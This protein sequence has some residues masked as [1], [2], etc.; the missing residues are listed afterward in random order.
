MAMTRIVPQPERQPSPAWGINA[1]A[2]W[3]KQVSA[4][5]P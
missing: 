4:G 5:G 3:E 2:D 1:G